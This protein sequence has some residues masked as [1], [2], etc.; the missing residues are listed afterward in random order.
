MLRSLET[1]YLDQQWC[2]QKGFGW[3]DPPLKLNDFFLR[4][5]LRDT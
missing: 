4:M 2:N 1:W 3:L 5:L